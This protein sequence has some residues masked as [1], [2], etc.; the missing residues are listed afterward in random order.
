MINF[1]NDHVSKLFGSIAVLG[2]VVNLLVLAYDSIYRV[3]PAR[4]LVDIE[5]TQRHN[6]A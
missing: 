3:L 2:L 5:P 6:S 1:F 4:P